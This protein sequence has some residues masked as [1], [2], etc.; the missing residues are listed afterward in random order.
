MEDLPAGVVTIVASDAEAAP[1]RK[2]LR[3]EDGP[4]ASA[5]LVIRLRTGVTLRGRV[6]DQHGDPVPKGYIYVAGYEEPLA[7][8]QAPPAED[9]GWMQHQNT[10]TDDEGRFELHRVPTGAKPDLSFNADGYD[11]A[12]LKVEDVW[13]EVELVVNRHDPE[14]HRKRKELERRMMAVFQKASQAKDDAE[15]EALQAEMQ[16]IQE[17]M[18]RLHT[19]SGEAEALPAEAEPVP[20]E[21]D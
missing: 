15:R 13:A 5:P 21:S 8:G 7:P 9:P 2:R 3:I 11:H 6:V 4:T 1:A 17:E 16:A 10:H 20:A 19:E 18:G 14:I 12:S